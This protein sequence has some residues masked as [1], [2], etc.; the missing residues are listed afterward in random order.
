MSCKRAQLSLLKLPSAADI[1]KIKSRFIQKH[2]YKPVKTIH[3]MKKQYIS[4]SAIVMDL[5]LESSVA[6]LL[7]GS[8]EGGASQTQTEDEAWT[9]KKQ[10]NCYWD[11]PDDYDSSQDY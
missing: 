5:H 4:P 6:Q 9:Q 3:S 8:R 2:F 11:Y 1:M 7:V 10:D